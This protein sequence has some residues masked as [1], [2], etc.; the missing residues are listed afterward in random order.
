VR[1]ICAH[2]DTRINPGER[3]KELG[4]ALDDAR[5]FDGPA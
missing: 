4:P 1:V 3:I 2:L 5:L